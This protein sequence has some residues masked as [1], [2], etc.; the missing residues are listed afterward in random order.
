MTRCWVVPGFLSSELCLDGDLS[1]LLWVN[2]SRLM[3]GEIGKMRLAPNGIDPGPPDG[4][5]LF[6]GFPL[7]D[8]WNSAL[9]QLLE[10][11][12]PRGYSVVGFSYDWRKGIF[13]GGATL[14]SAI[15][16]RES[17]ADPCTIVA[18]SMGGLVARVAWADLVGSGHTS[19]V[20]RIVTLGTP[21]QGS[22]AGV[23]LASGKDVYLDQLQFVSNISSLI[24]GLDGTWSPYRRFTVA[25][26]AELALTWPGLYQLFPILGGSDAQSDSLRKFLYDAALWHGIATPSQTHLDFAKTVVGPW[27]LSEPSQPPSWV[28]TSV[29]G[30]GVPTPARLLNVDQLGR[31]AAIGSTDQG[32]G[33]VTITSAEVVNSA[34]YSLACHHTDLPLTTVQSGDLVKWILEVREP[35]SPPP[36]PVMIEGDLV[37][38]FTGPPLAGQIAGFTPSAACARGRCQC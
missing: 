30:T 29:S 31:P 6:I 27:L 14:A 34:V 13:E 15:R 28:L 11:L 21:H 17:A 19:Y 3:Q 8:Y 26:L 16:D 23:M 1:Q 33:V 4:V 9:R 7:A 5:R 35:P 12:K 37:P 32:D 25:E 10:Q 22:Y 20:R 18:H 38:I 24:L 2:T 36:P